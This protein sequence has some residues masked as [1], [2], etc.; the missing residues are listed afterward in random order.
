MYIV[1]L[2]ATFLLFFGSFQVVLAEID[3]KKVEKMRQALTVNGQMGQNEE[4]EDFELIA[5]F[6][7]YVETYFE[8]EYPHLVPA[9]SESG[10]YA[11]YFEYQ[12]RQSGNDLFFWPFITV[13]FLLILYITGNTMEKRDKKLNKT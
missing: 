4:V 7:K 3:S 1:R 9:I 10:A 6:E 13:F 2:L 8:T 12:N 11:V 5:D